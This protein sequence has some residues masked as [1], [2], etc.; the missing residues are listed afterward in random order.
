MVQFYQ[1]AGSV[2]ERAAQT[3]SYFD[4]SWSSKCVPA[5]DEQIPQLETS[6]LSTVTMFKSIPWLPKGNGRK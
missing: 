4:K 3:I 5:S 2:M 6:V 1:D